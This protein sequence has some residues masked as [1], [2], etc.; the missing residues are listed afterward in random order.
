MKSFTLWPLKGVKWLKASGGNKDSK[1]RKKRAEK[2][3]RAEKHQMEREKSLR[4]LK[5][6][7]EK[8][9]KL[10]KHQKKNKPKENVW[11]DDLKT[12]KKWPGLVD[13]KTLR[14]FGHNVNGISYQH[15]YIDWLMTIQQM[16][17]YQADVFCLAEVNLDM[18]KP[19]VKKDL[20]D[21]MNIYDKYTSMSMSSSLESHSES[22]FK[23]GGTLTTVRG[24]WSGRVIEKGKDSLGRWSYVTLEG[25]HEKKLMIITTYRVCRKNSENGKI[26]IR[27]QQERD[28]YKMRKSLKDPREELLIDLEKEIKQ[29]HI[30][31]YE[32][33]IFSDMNEDIN[34]STRINEFM[35]SANLKNV[36]T[37]KHIGKELPCTYDRGSKCLDIMMMSK[38]IDDKAIRKCGILPF[39]HGMPSDHRSF[40]ADFDTD[41]LFTNAHANSTERN[42]KRFTTTQTK[43]CDR[44]LYNLESMM[45]ES[46]IFKKIAKLEKEMKEYIESKEGDLANLINE[47]KKLFNKTTQLMIASDKK[48]GRAHYKNGKPSSPILTEAASDVLECKNELRRE[49]TRTD[50]DED[51]I[52]ELRILLKEAKREF[53]TI[54]EHSA[55]HRE[56]FLQDL[57]TKK[58]KSWNLTSQQAAVVIQEAEASKKLHGKHKY[59]LKPKNKGAT[60][61]IMVPAPTTECIPKPSDITNA[62]VQMRVDEPSQV[63]NILLRQNFRQLLKSKDSIFSQGELQGKIGWNAETEFVNELL[64]G[65]DINKNKSADNG[66]EILKNFIKAMKYAEVENGESIEE[67]QWTY[68]IEEY[69]STFSKTRESTACGPSGLHMSHWKA[70][71]ERE[72]IMKVHAFFVWAAFQFGFSYKRWEVSWH[73]MLQ[74]KELPYSQKMRIIQLLKGDFN[75]ALKFLMGRRLMWYITK[76][77]LIDAATYGS[78][79]GKTAT[80]AL[81]NL[82]LIFDQ[83]RIKKQNMGM[84]FNDA[85]GCYDRIP[86]SLAE[87]ALRRVGCPESIVRTHTITQR[88]MKH[89]I[90]TGTGVS[91]G[92]ISFSPMIKMVMLSGIISSIFGPIGGV[93]QGGGGSPIIWLAVILMMLQAYKKTNQGIDIK[94]PL[95]AEIIKYWIIS[96]VDDNTIIKH[97]DNGVQLKRCLLA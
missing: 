31:G 18:S 97:F 29:K 60:K 53:K 83:C 54:Q 75:G 14:V 1:K 24:N 3:K 62:A 64:Q 11:G 95:T 43:K 81:L 44:Y 87:I 12:D 80:D 92:Y 42:F 96:Y 5:E 77:G 90:K 48:A 52:Q 2:Q 55:E 39:Y 30:K 82:Q 13:G 35:E 37:T 47:C 19:E 23:P 71:L 20:M 91:E 34:N 89:H 17:E 66:N 94:N 4:K 15:G 78:R 36:M 69:K 88:N 51:K 58:A 38:S 7:N 85:D 67:Y 27:K 8:G 10:K 74:K 59:Y 16:E 45:E 33:I 57:Y 68:G 79:L 73:V 49:S 40:F 76:K 6:L 41:Y 9:K 32:F 84:L 25:K 72:Q 56:K 63:F 46:R 21:R 28:L 65:T 86:P 93:G 50:S 22:A 26:T 70:A 61:Y